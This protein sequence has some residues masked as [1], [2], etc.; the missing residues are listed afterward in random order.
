MLR[1]LAARATVPVCI[2]VTGFVVVCCFLLYGVLKENITRDAVHYETGLADT[3]ITATRY[4]MLRA[5]REA[6]RVIIDNIGGQP[7]I[8]HVRI[9]NQH[10]VIMFSHDSREVGHVVDKRTAGCIG[11]HSGPVPAT[12]LGRMEQARQFR[13]ERGVPVI[14]ITAPIYNQPACA[15][16]LCH[17]HPSDQRVLGTLDIG[18]SAVPLHR[19]LTSLREILA[20]FSLLVLILTVGGVA[21]ILRR[22]VFLPIRQLVAYADRT[23]AGTV[24][25]E[26]LPR[27]GGEL[28]QLADHI[29]HQEE[30]LRRTGTG[31]ESRS[32]SSDTAP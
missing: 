27:F 24:P 16:A 23:A 8:E 22:A 32:H 2:A 11:C 4:S 3:L 12:T 17:V 6:M 14:A 31:P 1:S 19:S 28:D 18:Y 15:T 7:G 29:R 9:F 25:P 13:N 20:I 26:E 30:R 21:A 5:D 10:G